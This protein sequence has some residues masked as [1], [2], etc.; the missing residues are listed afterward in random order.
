MPPVTAITYLMPRYSGL[1]QMLQYA[2]RSLEHFDVDIV[3]FYIP[4]LVQA[5]RYDRLGN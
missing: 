5:L 4:Q 2:I 3:F 1:P